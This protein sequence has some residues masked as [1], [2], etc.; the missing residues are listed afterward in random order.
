MHRYKD[1]ATRSGRLLHPSSVKR[2]GRV[3]EWVMVEQQQNVF[4]NAVVDML[5]KDKFKGHS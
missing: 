1:E 3:I 4:N 2:V 5:Q